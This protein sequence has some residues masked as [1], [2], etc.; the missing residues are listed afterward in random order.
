MQFLDPK[1]NVSKKAF[2]IGDFV[3]VHGGHM[4]HG[5]FLAP[6]SGGGGRVLLISPCVARENF[7]P[8]P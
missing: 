2:F 6:V 7:F 8:V 1:K 3:T 4:D 5:I